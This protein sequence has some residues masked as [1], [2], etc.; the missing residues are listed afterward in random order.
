MWLLW[1]T[2]T[3]PTWDVVIIGAGAAGLMAGISAGRRGLRVVVL[4]KNRKPGVKILMSGGTRCNITHATDN[5]GIVAAYGKHQGPFLRSA[6]AAFT[7]EQTLAFFNSAGVATKVEDTGKIF[8]VSNKALDV[9]DAL[10]QQL[11]ASGATLALAE[12]VRA[13]EPHSAGFAVTT[14]L[15]TVTTRRLLITTGGLS[16]PGCGTTGDGYAWARQFGHTLVPTRPALVPITVQP[17]WI[18]QLR[19]VTLPDVSV[20]VQAGGT[21]LTRRRGSLLFAHFGLTGPVALDASGAI[22][23]HP[24]PTALHLDVD[25]LPTLPEPACHQWLLDEAKAGGKRQLGGIVGARLPRS[26]GE[27]VLAQV[28]VPGERK[29]SELGKTERTALV[30]ALKR[31]RLP[32]RGT[33]GYEK[34]E[35]T[36]GGVERCEI[37]PHTMQSRCQPGLFLAGEVLDLDGPI[38]GYNFQAAWSTGWLAGQSV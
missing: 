25:L 12:P 16:F 21:T 14:N 23:G 13:V 30:T 37:D 6:L 10:V 19:G 22:S 2:M 38:G 31:L 7:V 27:A 34:A 33:L 29:L 32:V 11:H 28:Q 4:E 17:E 15:R 36:A 8:P 1:T 3:E 20:Q 18:T 5:A 24:T 26:V 35:V 9:L